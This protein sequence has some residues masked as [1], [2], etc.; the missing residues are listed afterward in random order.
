MEELKDIKCFLLDMDGTI[1]LGNKL[2]KGAKKFLNKL[3][4]Q[5]KKYIFLTNNSSRSSKYYQNKLNRLGI[6]VN[7]NNIISSGEVTASY[8]KNIKSNARVYVVGTKFLKNEIKKFDIKIV[9]DTD[10][11]IDFV[12]LGFDTTLTYKKIWDAHQLILKGVKYIATNPDFVCPLAEGKT[13]PDCGSIIKLLKSSTGKEPLIIG[14]PYLYIIEYVINKTGINK[15][16]MAIVGDRLYT[17]I[18]TAINASITGILV[19]SGE[20]NE[21]ILKES[22][23]IPD[24]VF[25]DINQLRKYI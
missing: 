8:I 13:M 3:D 12:V 4:R 24:Y 14:K 21:N 17:D 1:Y 6:K 23:I 19:L 7:L 15:E 18:Q 22:R 11:E 25:A 9:E 10:K 20:T 16:R 5:G 2:L